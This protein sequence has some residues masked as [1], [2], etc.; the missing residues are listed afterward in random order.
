MADGQSDHLA[1][2]GLRLLGHR[3]PVLGFDGA[4]MAIDES[5][6]H[7]AYANVAKRRQNLLVETVA[8]G[9]DGGGGAVLTA[10][11]DEPRL[12]DAASRVSGVISAAASMR[13]RSRNASD[14]AFSAAA[15]DRP[16]RWTSRMTPS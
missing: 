16:T 7:L 9:G 14:R 13:A 2:H 6:G 8:V 15:F 4:E 1:E 3:G 10:E 11:V 5:D 12:G